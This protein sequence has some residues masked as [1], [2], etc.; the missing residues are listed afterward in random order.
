MPRRRET[1]A[2]TCACLAA[3]KLLGDFPMPLASGKLLGG[4][5]PITSSVPQACLCD[6]EEEEEEEEKSDRCLAWGWL[7]S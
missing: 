6:D 7:C 1:S 4:D 2:F 5:F 3:E